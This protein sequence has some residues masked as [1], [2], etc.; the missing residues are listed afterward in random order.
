MLKV[1]VK[2]HF[3]HHVPSKIARSFVTIIQFTKEAEDH[4]RDHRSWPG[5]STVFRCF[6]YSSRLLNWNE[7]CRIINIASS[8]LLLN[9][10]DQRLMDIRVQGHSKNIPSFRVALSNSLQGGSCELESN[11]PYSALFDKKPKHSMT[12]IKYC[13]HDQRHAISG[14]AIHPCATIQKEK[15][16]FKVRCFNADT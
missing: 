4:A 9:I 7:Y 5:W 12:I 15:R 10:S 14:I 1:I 16:I 13:C 2:Q 3:A 11:I 8:I 6:C